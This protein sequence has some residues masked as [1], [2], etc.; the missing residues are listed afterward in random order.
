MNSPEGLSI[1]MGL[2]SHGLEPGGPLI[3]GGITIPF[4][5]SLVG[6]SDGDVLL[7]AIMDALLS[8]ADLP[9][10]G[11]V[12]PGIDENRGRSSVD[13]A[14]EVARRVREKGVEVLSI[15]SVVLAEQPHIAPLRMQLRESVAAALELDVHQ[16]NVKGK[17]AD[18]FG[19]VGR[20]ESIEA[21]AIALVRQAATEA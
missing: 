8:A 14:H 1:G 21:Q 16:V 4:E 7:H 13:M 10:L 17:T 18:G 19:P 9:D 5:K 3:L 20:G 11:E 15:D 2:D 12:F 6:H